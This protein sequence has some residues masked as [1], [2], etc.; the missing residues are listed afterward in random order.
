MSTARRIVR[1]NTAGPI[2]PTPEALLA[3]V[4]HPVI[5]IAEGERIV[6]ANPPA[7]QF[8]E[9]SAAWLKRQPL[10]ALLPFGSQLPR[11]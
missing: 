10:S 3:A 6:F 7:E 2:V 8:F 1:G 11:R 5:A 9:M 4:P